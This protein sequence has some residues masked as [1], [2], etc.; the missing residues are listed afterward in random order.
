MQLLVHTAALECLSQNKNTMNEKHVMKSL[1]TL[2]FNSLI[3]ESQKI[4]KK[5]EKENADRKALMNE[6]KGNELTYEESLELANRLHEEA[7]QKLR[8]KKQE[9]AMKKN[10][11]NP[12]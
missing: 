11:E 8:L 12:Q 7:L 1:E 10:T 5:I 2:E 3:E 9:E 4:C 6:R